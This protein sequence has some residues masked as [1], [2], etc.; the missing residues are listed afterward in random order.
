MKHLLFWH[1]NNEAITSFVCIW[2]T[3]LDLQPRRVKQSLPLL[4]GPLHGGQARHH[5]QVLLRGV[6]MSS[7]I[8][9]DHVVDQNHGIFAQCSFRFI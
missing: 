1:S 8:R 9:N 5:A 3:F 4:L 6:P 2:I 7:S